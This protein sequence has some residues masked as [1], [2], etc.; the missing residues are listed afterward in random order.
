MPAL[1]QSRRIASSESDKDLWEGLWTSVGGFSGRA[2]RYVLVAEALGLPTDQL[3]ALGQ[4]PWSLVIDLDPE[5]DKTGLLRHAGSVLEGYRGLHRFDSEIPTVDF[6]RGTAWMMASGWGDKNQYFHD[7]TVWKYHR[8]SIVREIVEQAYNPNRPSPFYVIVLPGVS[9]DPDAPMARLS[10][11]IGAI[12]EASRGGARICLLGRREVAEKV[13]HLDHVCL[14]PSSFVAFAADTFGTGLADNRAQVPGPNGEMRTIR[15]SDLRAMQEN[16]HVLHS[17]ILSEPSDNGAELSE[18]WRG[19]PPTWS[20]LHLGVDIERDIHP[21]LLRELSERLDEY[22]NQTV[23]LRHS[24]GAGGTTAALRAAWDLHRRHPT[25]IVH[26]YSP[27]LADRIREL[28]LAAERPVLV[29]L[30]SRRISR[31]P[32][33]RNSTAFSPKTTAALSCFMFG[34]GSATR[35]RARCAGS[36]YRKEVGP[37]FSQRYDRPPS[38]PFPSGLRLAT[39]PRFSCHS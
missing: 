36:E 19:R 23:I 32:P 8:L 15:L 13:A 20:E 30:R 6:S 33:G 12:D 11:V 16:L 5:S 18:F 38:G 22:R 27:A 35:P 3:R 4:M 28:F 37:L 10:A 21:R 17:N 7:Y 31:R 25:A 26:K 34:A 14:D 39:R 24:P 29:G 2:G 1:F 9:L